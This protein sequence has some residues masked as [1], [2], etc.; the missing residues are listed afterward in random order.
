MA[1]LKSKN[2]SDTLNLEDFKY[3]TYIHSHATALEKL[4]INNVILQQ[5]ANNVLQSTVNNLKTTA[6][7]LHQLSHSDAVQRWYNETHEADGKRKLEDD[8]LKILLQLM[9]KA[10]TEAPNNVDAIVESVIEKIFSSPDGKAAYDLIIAESSEKVADRIVSYLSKK[11]NDVNWTSIT[12]GQ[13]KSNTEIY[14]LLV[15]S[16]RYNLKGYLK[17]RG[18]LDVAN[19][20]QQYV[21]S[22]IAAGTA[23][24][25]ITG[26]ELKELIEDRAIAGDKFAIAVSSGFLLEYFVLLFLNKNPMQIGPNIVSTTGT[27]G[28]ELTTDVQLIATEGGQNYRIGISLK[29]NMTPENATGS[30]FIKTVK[31]AQGEDNPFNLS[32]EEYLKILYVLGNYKALSVFAAPEKY[33][34]VL[35]EGESPKIPNNKVALP[36]DMLQWV[37]DL[38]ESWTYLAFVKGLVG[39]LFNVQPNFQGTEDLKAPPLFLGFYEYDYYM[40]DILYALIDIIEKGNSQKWEDVIQYTRMTWSNPLFHKVF[41]K[42]NLQNLFI[43]KKLTESNSDNRYND[44]YIGELDTEEAEKAKLNLNVMSILENISNTFD[45]ELLKSKLFTAVRYNVPV[46][47][48]ITK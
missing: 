39:Q 4:N 18:V 47:S 43:A 38:Q 31:L 7:T 14:N 46:N 32:V 10:R 16:I 48:F 3:V 22:I 24:P 1:N 33:E 8:E 28:H 35:T 44:F 6:S 34:T 15:K 26:S 11:K 9:L 5:K 27:S 41:K 12:I 45:I 13:L 42:E 29:A 25:S 2:R 21:Q 37:L 17:A 36:G 40:S 23:D 19:I 30:S 20:I